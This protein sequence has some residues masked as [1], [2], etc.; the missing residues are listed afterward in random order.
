[1]SAARKRG[2][3]AARATTQPRR[4]PRDGWKVVPM[5]LWPMNSVAAAS[6]LGYYTTHAPLVCI[7]QFWS[8]CGWRPTGSA[9]RE[10]RPATIPCYRAKGQRSF[11]VLAYGIYGRTC[12]Q[13]LAFLVP[14]HRR[15]EA[16]SRV[17]AANSHRTGIPEFAGVP[18]RNGWGGRIRTCECRYQKPVP[19]HLATPQQARPHGRG[20]GLIAAQKRV[21][22]LRCSESGRS[23]GRRS[24][25]PAA[26]S[27]RPLRNSTVPR[28]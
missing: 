6:G 9:R 1:M 5:L 3:G 15:H 19:Y 8:L 28:T 7:P 11:L 18:M 14:H 26:A 21:E 27:G 10:N 20:S 2:G 23:P 25:W 22:R 12:P 4:V 24:P 16:K 17:F 13:I